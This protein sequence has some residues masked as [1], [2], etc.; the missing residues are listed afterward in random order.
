VHQVNPVRGEERLMA[1]VFFTYH[2][3]D[4]G[5][6]VGLL[7]ERLVALYGRSNVYNDVDN[8]PLGVNFAHHIRKSLKLC[9]LQLVIIGPQGADVH[10]ARVLQLLGPLRL[11]SST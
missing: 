7:S 6:L 1:K 8:I 5:S 4:S 2:R 11:R 3:T 9:V 10:T